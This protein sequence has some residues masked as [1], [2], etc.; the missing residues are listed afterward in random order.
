[1]PEIEQGAAKIYDTTCGING[2]EKISLSSKYTLIED[3]RDIGKKNDTVYV[4]HN[5]K[6]TKGRDY[7]NSIMIYNPKL[8]S[9]RIVYQARSCK[10]IGR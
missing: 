1:M 6:K 8:D 10:K 3:T 7:L 5:L 9:Y 2:N 4:L